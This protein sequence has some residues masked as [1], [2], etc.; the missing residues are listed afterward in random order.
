MTVHGNIRYFGL[1][2]F[3]S[4]MDRISFGKKRITSLKFLLNSYSIQGTFRFDFASQFNFF[5]ILHLTFYTYF[6][7][8]PS[9]QI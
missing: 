3:R 9:R 8:R 6:G 1:F 7:H 4:Q 2:V 5:V